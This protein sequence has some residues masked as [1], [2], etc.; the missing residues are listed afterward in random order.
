V[1]HDGFDRLGE[2]CTTAA[3]AA[4]LTPIGDLLAWSAADWMPHTIW[5]QWLAITFD[6][7][8]RAPAQKALQFGEVCGST[9][10]LFLA[11]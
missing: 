11:S 2:Q 4:Q 9:G 5:R 6:R 3:I 7:P 8:S 1:T 10:G